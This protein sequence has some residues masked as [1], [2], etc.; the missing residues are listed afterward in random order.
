MSSGQDIRAAQST[1]TG[2]IGLMKWGTIACVIVAAI[3]IL[4]IS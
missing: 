1:Y 4:L 3:V 2:F